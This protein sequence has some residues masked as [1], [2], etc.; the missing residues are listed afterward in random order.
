MKRI[1]AAVGL[2]AG[3]LAFPA[4][5]LAEEGLAQQV[6]LAQRYEHGEGVLLDVRQARELYCAAADAGSGPAAFQLGWI[7]FLGRGVER[8]DVVATRW[9]LLAAKRGLRQALNVIDRFH[10]VGD[11]NPP[12]CPGATGAGRPAVPLVPPQRIAQLVAKLAPQ[13]GL[14]P[15]LVLAVIKVES[16]FQTN[17]VSPKNAQGLMQLIPETAARFGV[18]DPFAV[19]A[20]L[21]GGMRY[22]RWL[23]SYFRGDVTLTLAAYNAGEGAVVDHHGVPP[24]RETQDYVQRVHAYYPALRHPYDPALAT[25][26]PLSEHPID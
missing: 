15:R 1:L 21:L 11:A 18:R 3:L 13:H 23:L 17:A 16:G 20:N 26:S 25:A 24:F 2:L 4:C 8:D 14:D 12:N 7:Y 19:E 6:E 5:V 22:L 10:L 9:F